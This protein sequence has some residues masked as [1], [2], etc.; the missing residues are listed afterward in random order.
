MAKKYGLKLF[1]LFGSSITGK[2]HKES[3]IDVA[4]L[5]TQNLTIREEAKIMISLAP[6]L[7]NKNVDLINIHMAPPLLLYAI[8][9]NG[10][11][12]Y[13]S[14]PLEFYRLRAYAFKRYIENK[15]LFELKQKKLLIELNL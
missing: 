12:L 10:K 6:I 1:V 8:A 3:D 13:A 2:T 9:K 14:N 5:G 7:K 11:V 15:P 4:Y